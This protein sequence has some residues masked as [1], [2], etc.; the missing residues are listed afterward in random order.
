[1][2]ESRPC[3]DK[4][5]TALVYK[6]A[7]PLGTPQVQDVLEQPSN[8]VFGITDK[9]DLFGRNVSTAINETMRLLPDDRLSVPSLFSFGGTLCR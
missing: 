7:K 2:T 9:G 8:T 3:F 1:M 5:E 4:D 6:V